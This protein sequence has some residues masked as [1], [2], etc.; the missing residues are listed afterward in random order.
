MKLFRLSIPSVSKRW[1]VFSMHYNWYQ[2]A[3]YQIGFSRNRGRER[4]EMR[5][6]GRSESQWVDD[7]CL[8]CALQSF[9]LKPS[10]STHTNAHSHALSTKPFKTLKK[11]YFTSWRGTFHKIFMNE[12]VGTK[13]EG[14]MNEWWRILSFLTCLTCRRPLSA[15]S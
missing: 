6:E 3:F 8:S 10:V 12:G 7:I 13:Q 2:L 14:G 1:K 11:L 15:M 5:A 9:L 4:K